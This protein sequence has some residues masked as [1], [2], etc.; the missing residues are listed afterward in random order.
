MPTCS[1]RCVAS[2]HNVFSRYVSQN[3]F[4]KMYFPKCIFQNVSLKMYFPK[5]IEL[6]EITPLRRGTPVSNAFTHQMHSPLFINCNWA[7]LCWMQCPYQMQWSHPILNFNRKKREERGNIPEV[8]NTEWNVFSGHGAQSLPLSGE[9]SL[10]FHHYCVCGLWTVCLWTVDCVCGP[11]DHL[12]AM[13]GPPTLRSLDCCK[14]PGVGL[15]CTQHPEKLLPLRPL[16]D[17]R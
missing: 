14:E 15:C 12:R 6:D 3:V 7:I 2:Q 1:A 4:P 16:L 5:C 11:L 17:L 13:Q 8:G 9:A 10:E